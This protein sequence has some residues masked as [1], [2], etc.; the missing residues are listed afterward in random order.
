MKYTNWQQAEN[1][2]TF[3]YALNDEGVNHFDLKVYGHGMSQE[4]KDEIGDMIVNA[5]KNA[6]ENDAL[7]ATIAAQAA[8]IELLTA[9]KTEFSAVIAKA[10]SLLRST[11]LN[12]LEDAL[13]ELDDLLSENMPKKTVPA[14]QPE[15]PRLTPYQQAQIKRA[16]SGK[17]D[18]REGKHA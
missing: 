16:N 18:E 15:T 5:P 3:I 4:E 14:P 6:A 9:Q 12:W 7:R 11:Q 10:Q 1:D 8:E 13:F 17:A 2:K